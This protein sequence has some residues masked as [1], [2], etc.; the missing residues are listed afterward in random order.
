[1]SRHISKGKKVLY[2]FLGSVALVMA[3]VGVALPGVPGIPFILL[4]AY[5]YVQCSDKMY[6]WVLN[7]R[8]FGKVIREFQAH[9]TIPLKFKLIVI[10]QLWVSI[11]VAEIWF[12]KDL[13]WRLIIIAS[14]IFFSVLIA[15]LKGT[16]KL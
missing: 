6:N 4:T 14:G 1:M 2:F 5:F 15:R 13:T 8:L 7:Q 10:S 9:K 11:T 12:V 3:Y 16:E